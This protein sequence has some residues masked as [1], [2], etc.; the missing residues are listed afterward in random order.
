MKKVINI[1]F[2]QSIWSGCF[3]LFDYSIFEMDLE[4]N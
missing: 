4:Y 3:F 1:D 2:Q